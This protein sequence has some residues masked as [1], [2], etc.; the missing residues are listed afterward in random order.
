L[1]RPVGVSEVSPV[2][3]RHLSTIRSAERT[4]VA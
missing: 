4:L 3:E 2:V 1:G